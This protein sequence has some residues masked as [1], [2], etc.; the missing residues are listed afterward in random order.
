[1]SASHGDRLPKW[2]VPALLVA[3]AQWFFAP[4]RAEAKCGDYVLIGGRALSGHEAGHEAANS[5]MPSSSAHEQAGENVAEPTHSSG[6]PIRRAPCSGPTCSNEGPRPAGAPPA[7]P[8]IVVRHWG[9]MAAQ[10]AAAPSD[11]RFALLEDDAGASRNTGCSIYRPP[12]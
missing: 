7:P 5:E 12:R 6:T 8:E 1:M 10:A 9:M 3:A 4:G 11:P 2:L